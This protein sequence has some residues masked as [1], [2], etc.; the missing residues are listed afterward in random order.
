MNR[1]SGI[2]LVLVLAINGC[3]SVRPAHIYVL[4][5]PAA[6]D[7]A[8]YKRSDG[9]HFL[10]QPISLPDYLDTT[11]IVTRL[12]PN[13]L[14]S[15]RTGEWGERLSKGLNHSLR[16]ALAVR[17]PLDSV[18]LGSSM[19]DSGRKIAVEIHALDVWSDGHCVLAASWQIQD[20]DR[21]S[22]FASQS[23]TFEIARVERSRGGDAAVVAAMANA[24]SKLAESIALGATRVSGPSSLRRD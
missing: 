15:S 17:L 1:R 22:T 7:A 2:I 6:L 9:R 21:G 11:D 5:T 20:K 13:E 14:V 19:E 3:A 23:G 10:L 16:A 24:V 4:S 8:N 18:I 12:G